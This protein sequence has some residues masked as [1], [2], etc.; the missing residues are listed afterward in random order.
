VE[1]G[2]QDDRWQMA[3]ANVLG[4]FSRV[5]G[6]PSGMRSLGLCTVMKALSIPIY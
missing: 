5:E 6:E 4:Q 3:E 1:K 2:V